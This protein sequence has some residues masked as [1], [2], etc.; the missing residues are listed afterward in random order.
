LGGGMD[1]SINEDY[2]LFMLFI[3]YISDKYGNS[4]DFNPLVIS[5]IKIKARIFNNEDSYLR[6]FDNHAAKLDRTL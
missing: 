3:K 6:I 1:A 5:L 2:A 4:D